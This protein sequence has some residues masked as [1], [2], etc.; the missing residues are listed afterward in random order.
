MENSDY[1]HINEEFRAINAL[2]QTY[3]EIIFKYDFNDDTFTIYEDIPQKPLKA[4]HETFKIGSIIDADL[5]DPE[6]INDLMDTY[7][8]LIDGTPKGSVVFRAKNERGDWNWHQVK[9]TTIFE[10]EM[11]AAYAII[12]YQNI[13]D[14]RIK[15][16]N[17]QRFYDFTSVGI[18]NTLFSLE[19]NLNLDIFESFEGQI[20][21]GFKFDQKLTVLENVEE[22][23]DKFHPQ[24]REKLI[25]FFS[26]KHLI[27]LHI[28]GH[29]RGI[30]DFRIKYKSKYVWSRF[31]YHIMRDPYSCNYI[32]WLSIRKIDEQK[33]TEM[34]LLTNSQRD[35][36]TGVY[37]SGTFKE[38]VIKKI[39]TSDD[40]LV[41]A[42]VMVG[43]DNFVKVNDTLGYKYGDK[44]LRDIARTIRLLL[45][46]EDVI[47]RLYGTKFIIYIFNK[48]D[49]KT[50]DQI[51]QLIKMAI[52]RETEDSIKLSLSMGAAFFGEDGKD[53]DTLFEKT[54]L[55]LT[56]AK[57]SGKN[58]LILYKEELMEQTHIQNEVNEFPKEDNDSNRV[59][60]RTFGYFDVFIDGRAILIPH[61]KAKELLA[62]LVHRR[63][64]FVTPDEIIAHLWEDE[65]V[66]KVTM[67]RS[68]KVFMLLKD[69]LKEY[70]VDDILESNRGS[71]RIILEKIN[72]DLCKFL[73]GDE[74]YASMYN[75]FYM[76]NYSWGEYAIAEI[77]KQAQNYKEKN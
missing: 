11:V 24:Y 28:R 41:S 19:Y 44:I 37:H 25:K 71:R 75:G 23:M 31:L 43:V 33:Q 14:K 54:Y 35:E 76:L 73:S 58:K 42:L 6:S 68:R 60:I 61:G 70:D 77:E 3:K 34:K 45:K 7:S 30:V 69:T 21:Q 51:L 40:N 74:R 12:Y 17:S 16:M 2:L 22:N 13:T 36:L 62:L 20:P 66:N 15:E 52:G 4:L 29:Y 10:D 39:R 38:K 67:A 53:F 5:V 27:G 64:G 18:N 47:G 72:C 32:L 26:T 59:D 1:L 63:G 65:E 9:Y 8:N 55:A 48:R 56:N 50:V 57:E 46:K 49:K